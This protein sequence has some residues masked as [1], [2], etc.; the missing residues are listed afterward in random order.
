MIMR[1]LRSTGWGQ[2]LDFV[3][4]SFFEVMPARALAGQ[5]RSLLASRR[6]TEGMAREARAL[7]RFLGRRGMDLRVRAREQEIG[8]VEPPDDEEAR[9]ERGQTVLRLYF[10][11]IL[12]RDVALL[13]VR[14]GAFVREEG[15]LVFA[16]SP[17]FARWDPEFARAIRQVYRGFYRDEEATFEQGLEALGL[18]P[19]RDLFIRHFGDGDQSAVRFEIPNFTKSFHDVFVR[20]RE[21]G[22]RLHA[23][24][25]PLGIHLAALY[26]HLETLGR[27]FDVRAAFAAADAKATE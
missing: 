23:D 24:F 22:T 9:Q 2:L 20:C 17:G 18:A 21:H 4:P 16:P 3:S 12:R 1:L 25:V 8:D 26:E 27:P 11:Q 7:S 5:A 13:D 19:A 14:C 15:G 10:E 6:D